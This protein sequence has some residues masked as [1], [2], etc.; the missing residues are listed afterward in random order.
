MLLDV[1]CVCAVVSEA[2][3]CV[4]ASGCGVCVCVCVC[5]VVSEVVCCVHASGCGVC[6]CVCCSV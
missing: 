6:V 4:H 2:V 5:A 1:V 3:C